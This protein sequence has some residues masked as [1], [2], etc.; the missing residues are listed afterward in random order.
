MESC[1][2]NCDEDEGIDENIGET[3]ITRNYVNT[4]NSN[5]VLNF[6]QKRVE[7]G[8]PQLL[9]GN[10]SN[11]TG[12]ASLMDNFGGGKVLPY[13]VAGSSSSKRGE[14]QHQS[15]IFQY[16]NT[17][18][19]CAGGSGGSGI[20]DGHQME[21]SQSS[22]PEVYLPIK[23]RRVK[24]LLESEIDGGGDIQDFLPPIPQGYH[25]R[26]VEYSSTS[27]A[28]NTVDCDN[29]EEWWYY[30]NQEWGR[31]RSHAARGS[32]CVPTKGQE[33]GVMRESANNCGVDNSTTTTTSNNYCDSV[34]DSHG[35]ETEICAKVSIYDKNDPRSD[36]Y[37]KWLRSYYPIA[38]T[39]HYPTNPFLVK[40]HLVDPTR[41][42][43]KFPPW[44]TPEG[45]KRWDI[46]KIAEAKS[47][48]Y[49]DSDVKIE[50]VKPRR[51]KDPAAVTS[52]AA[53]FKKPVDAS[54]GDMVKTKEP[55]VTFCKP[56]TVIS[57]VGHSKSYEINF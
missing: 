56:G 50:M 45:L 24:D 5:R 41:C 33:N 19:L 27:Q 3:M 14:Y 12:G 51:A 44:V 7:R 16:E 2:E 18:G 10:P 4:D 31:S 57:Y 26:F 53:V 22:E 38:F 1:K 40:M 20:D 46:G 55:L 15:R 30:A 11:S 54:F 34:K 36:E 21:D 39:H 13:S 28:A 29:S 8:R 43:N 37:R 52:T 49:S 6:A 23:K 47:S 25:H 35:Q 32:K 9:S 42:G 48:L 17:Q